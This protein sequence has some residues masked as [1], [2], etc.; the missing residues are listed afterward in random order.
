MA[1]HCLLLLHS[2]RDVLGPMDRNLES[3][4]S[5]W[6]E[7]GKMRTQHGHM[8]ACITLLIKDTYSCGFDRSTTSKAV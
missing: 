4:I 6:P 2:W 5:L 8:K 7:G 3:H 1:G